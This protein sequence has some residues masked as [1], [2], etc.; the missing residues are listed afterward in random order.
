MVDLRRA[1]SCDNLD[2]SRE[3]EKRQLQKSIKAEASKEAA[4]AYRFKAIHSMNKV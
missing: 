1:F 3:M 2:L 4:N